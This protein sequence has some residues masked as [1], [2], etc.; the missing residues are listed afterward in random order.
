MLCAY[1]SDEILPAM[2]DI[3]PRR[4]S[5]TQKRWFCRPGAVQSRP[6]LDSFFEF[7]CIR[8]AIAPPTFINFCG[9]LSKEV[10]SK[11]LDHSDRPTQSV[12]Q[13]S[14]EH[15]RE[16]AEDA[17]KRASEAT[18]PDQRNGYLKMAVG[19]HQM[20]TDKEKSRKDFPHSGKPKP[21]KKDQH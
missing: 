15:Y 18:S 16:C 20:A 1:T 21:R 8:N 17:L 7:L 10:M 4:A 19:W 3:F 9:T 13:Q 6:L 12:A 14:A 5:A 11:K 2:M